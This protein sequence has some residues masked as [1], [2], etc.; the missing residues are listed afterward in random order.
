MHVD[1]R[2]RGFFSFRSPRI[3]DDSQNTLQALRQALTRSM[4]EIDGAQEKIENILKK[5][6]NERQLRGKQRLTLKNLTSIR[7]SVFSLKTIRRL[8]LDF[9]QPNQIQP[10]G[11]QHGQANHASS[12]P[13]DL[14]TAP[15]L[16]AV[17]NMNS[18]SPLEKNSLL[19]LM[20]LKKHLPH[21]IN[22]EVRA[23]ED[24][25]SIN[26]KI[27][28]SRD[29]ANA[30]ANA[31]RKLDQMLAA[32]PNNQ[33]YCSACQ[34]LQNH[35]QYLKTQNDILNTNASGILNH[36]ANLARNF[37][38]SHASKLQGAQEIITFVKNKIQQMDNIDGNAK[39]EALN[40]LTEE[41]NKLQNKIN[42][43]N[44]MDD[45]SLVDKDQFEAFKKIPSKL[46]K[47]IKPCLSNLPE[48]VR[49]AFS[50]SKEQIQDMLTKK[51]SA[52]D[53]WDVFENTLH[54]DVADK[55]NKP[56][57][58]KITPLNKLPNVF[59][60]HDFNDFD[61]GG[62]PVKNYASGD[63][64]TPHI[65]NLSKTEIA[66]EN[67]TVLFSGYRHGT[68]AAF[69]LKDDPDAMNRASIQRTTEL[70]R[71]IVEDNDKYRNQI[72]D[73]T[74]PDN[75]IEIKLSS[76]SLL[77]PSNYLDQGEKS[78][79][80]TQCRAWDHFSPSTD[81]P[82]GIFKIKV[83]VPDPNH[84]GQPGPEKEIYIKPSISTFNFPCQFQSVRLKMGWD[85]SDVRNNPAFNRLV[86][87]SLN[88]TL[89]NADQI[90]DPHN[91]DALNRFVNQIKNDNSD[92]AAF[93]NNNQ[94]SQSEKNKAIILALEIKMLQQG[95]GLL[96]FSGKEHR[97]MKVDPYALPARVALLNNILGNET[98]FNC[99]SGKDRTGQL[100]AEVKTLAA[101]LSEVANET[102]VREYIRNNSDVYDILKNGSYSNKHQKKN[103]TKV[104]LNSGIMEIH[105]M[106]TGVMGSKVKGYKAGI[107]NLGGGTPNQFEDGAFAL[108][109]GKSKYAKS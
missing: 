106:N 96:S 69:G 92:L 50:F 17:G 31:I 108:Y 46:S 71:T 49:N 67:G 34:T 53:K 57:K 2:G 66:D 42:T 79:F 54:L 41:F 83:R 15:D 32:H 26:T 73:A 95:R 39:N 82:K 77:T 13:A 16:N 23:K 75:A 85:N 88:N 99:K 40:K 33:E 80:E 103:L 107:I 4:T 38:E 27:Q 43:V 18:I 8:E 30:C 63:R 68:T 52:S 105:K 104:A 7:S 51:L 36:K 3:N 10:Q 94:V 37:K 9:Q 35:F 72:E 28:V 65:T 74:N 109:K 19:F 56:F 48:N 24:I 86:G 60:S 1:S 59:V 45:M 22:T 14:E 101:T 64:K 81:N 87:S 55:T 89:H 90:L 61:V 6:L 70:L 11:N 76:V 21:N 44:Q 100:D 47:A 29:N 84:P 97:Q 12:R 5:H 58:F 98:C 102:D 93:L 20:N 25:N 78:M 62:H 91:Q